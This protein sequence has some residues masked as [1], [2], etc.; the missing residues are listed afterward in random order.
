MQI[1]E[2]IEHPEKLASDESIEPD[3]NATLGRLLH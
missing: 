1:D 3:S 2:S